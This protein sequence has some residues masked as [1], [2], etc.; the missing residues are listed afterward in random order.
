MFV[1]MRIVMFCILLLRIY[2]SV[3]V[4]YVCG[5]KERASDTSSEN[6]QVQI[7]FKQTFSRRTVFTG[8]QSPAR[9]YSSPFNTLPGSN[10]F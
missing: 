1:F 2:D 7:S 6:L 9:S 5:V 10:H 8:D 4:I 3:T